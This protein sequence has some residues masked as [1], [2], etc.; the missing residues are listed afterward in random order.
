MLPPDPG[1]C[2]ASVPSYAYDVETGLCL[3]FIYGGCEGN[4]NRFE[5]AEDCYRMC[6]GPRVGGTAYCEAS[7]ECHPISTG[8]C[9]CAP[10]SFATVV[11][12]NSQHLPIIE[13][14]KCATID[15]D[16]C[17]LDPAF[18]WFGASCR[19]NHCVAW[20]ARQEELTACNATNDCRL[21]NGLGCCEACDGG[22]QTL[23]AV[24]PALENQWV[25]P[26]GQ[27]PC[28]SC[29]NGGPKYPGNAFAECLNGR[30][31]PFL[32]E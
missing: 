32:L 10:A 21:R 11:G 16:A 15:C 19:E 31:V 14:T 3:P 5:T 30:C 12:V 2:E 24:N 8:C 9:G 1:P 28:P 22:Y 7:S 13:A 27:P 23:I 29:P 20:D 26:D 6:E 18:A 25:C 17:V 4:E